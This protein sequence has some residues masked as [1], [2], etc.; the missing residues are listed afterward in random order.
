MFNDQLYHT[1]EFSLT[2]YLSSKGNGHLVCFCIITIL[3]TIDFYHPLEI[4]P[5]TVDEISF[6]LTRFRFICKTAL[7]F[8]Y[9]C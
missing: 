6:R 2:I 7:K 1:V 3:K 4:R 5:K 9:N 8:E